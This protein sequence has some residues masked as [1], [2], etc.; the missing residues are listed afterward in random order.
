M[1]C[2][3]EIADIGMTIDK[4]LRLTLNLQGASLVQLVQL[5]KD[6][7]LDAILK[8]HS[9]KRSLDANAYYWKLLGELAKAL[10][11]SNEEL[12]NQLLDSYG[13]LAE[14]EDGNCIIHFLPETEDYLR[15]KHEHYKPT[16]IIV[17]FEGVR[18]CK[19]YRIKGSSQY[20]TREMS[21]LIDGL[22]SECKECGIETLTP[23][24]LE[25]MMVKFA[26]KDEVTSLGV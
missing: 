2:I 10:Q 8:K 15:Y 23:E 6:G 14:D 22:V 1:R 19:F 18:Y 11:T 16:G 13:T 12:H 5:Q 7:Q 24:E 4:K 17:E 20:N 26:K 25:R 9:D 21:R 3:A